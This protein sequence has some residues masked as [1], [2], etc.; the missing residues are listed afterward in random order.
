[1]GIGASAGGLDA[2]TALLKALPSDTGMSFVLIQHMD[3]TH[4]SVLASLLQRST[5]MPIR[6]ASDGT[7]VQPNHVYIVP[8]NALMTISDGNLWLKSRGAA[9]SFQDYPID[10]FLISLAEERKNKAIGVILS[11]TASDG[12]RGLQA[13]KAE[14][15]ITFAQDTESAAFSSMPASAVA[16]GCVDFTMP[17]GEIANELARIH[18]HPYIRR[19]P[20]AEPAPA[21]SAADGTRKIL[22]QLRA[23]T[24]VDFELYKPAM[25]SRRIARR[26]ALQ[27]IDR[28]DKYLELLRK[29]RTEL[30][31]LYEDILIHVTSFF[32]DPESF[33]AL[34]KRVLAHL[35]PAKT[36]RTIRIWVPGCS[37]GEEVYSI[38][39][40]LF[41]QL[42][43]RRSE[44]T[45]QI[46][47][48]DISERA[49]QRARAAI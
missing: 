24:G 29:N 49:V 26:M 14:G 4:Q 16:A 44:A 11:G 22:R 15:G 48:T 28:I 25:I 9:R 19:I 33:A 20:P 21:E 6:E 45:I 23:V 12:T 27:K 47:G 38:A 39:M 17:P 36:T 1:V 41:E 42:G 5:R 37:S 35:L 18:S 31:A 46:F 34:Q 2:F 32:R 40:L 30:N 8:P 7:K 3:P 13:I 10:Q 43:E